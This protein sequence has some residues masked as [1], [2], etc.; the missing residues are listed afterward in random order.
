M[1]EA[2]RALFRGVLVR[3]FRRPRMRMALRKYSS[4]I[5]LRVAGYPEVPIKT[6]SVL[7]DGF[8]GLV[9]FFAVD[10]KSVFEPAA[11]TL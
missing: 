11:T 3:S 7:L 6:T 9:P 2:D 4:H 8:K 1:L 10:E 5:R